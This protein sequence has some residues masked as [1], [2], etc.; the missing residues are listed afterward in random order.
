MA[1]AIDLIQRCYLG[2]EMRGSVLHFDPALPADLGRVGARMRYRRQT[3]DVEVNHDML[4]ISSRAQPAAPITIGYR[5]RFRDVTPGD[6]YELRLLKPEERDRD[7]NRG[8]DV[9]GP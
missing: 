2:I 8:P 7:E 3:L 5:G 6:T 1:G 4:R 9:R